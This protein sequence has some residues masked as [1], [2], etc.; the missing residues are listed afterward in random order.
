[1]LTNLCVFLAPLFAYLWGC[2]DGFRAA[3]RPASSPP[4][5]P[6]VSVFHVHHVTLVF[7]GGRSKET[8][9]V[10]ADSVEEVIEGLIL[11]THE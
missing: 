9:R 5:K 11:A 7:P 4:A 6:V 2:H 3:K 10:D 8:W 1:M